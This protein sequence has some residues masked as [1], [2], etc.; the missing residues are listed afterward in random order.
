MPHGTDVLPVVNA[1]LELPFV[2]KVATKDWHPPDHV[3]FARNH[4]P[5]HNR[6]FESAAVIRNPYPRRRRQGISTSSAAASSV[7]A[8]TATSTDDAA[9][10]NKAPATA[11]AN[12]NDGKDADKDANMEAANA[13]NDGAADNANDKA[14]DNAEANGNDDDDNHERYV[15]RLWP[16][17]CVQHTRGAALLPGLRAARL[18]SVVEKGTDARFETY[19]AFGAP[20]RDPPVPVSA[21]VPAASAANDNNDDDDNDD[22]DRDDDKD[23]DKDDN[24]L[25]PPPP[26]PDDD[27]LASSPLTRMLRAARVSHV[28]VTGLA[29]DYCV[30][31][32]ALDARE[33]GFAEVYVVREATRA[34]DPGERG[35]GAAEREL[36]AAGVRLVGVAGEEVGR[37]QRRGRGGK[38]EQKGGSR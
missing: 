11:N 36:R 24:A 17:H 23:D 5:P 31:Y 34:V 25:P 6:P 18:D 27:P 21:A 28:F 7:S 10:N 35:W 20:F 14:G 37:V 12:E 29:M 19:S 8:P 15:T 38:G 16:V 26:A 13:N 4:A 1:L 3:S 30:R 33:A 22:D 32:T 9:A 2:L